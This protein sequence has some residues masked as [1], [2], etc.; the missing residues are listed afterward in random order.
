MRAEFD[1]EFDRE[2]D[3]VLER[4]KQSHDLTVVQDLLA[5]WRHHAY[6][7]MLEPG[8]YYRMSADAEEVQRTGVAPRGSVDGEEIK[9]LVQQRLGR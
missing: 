9:S 3:Q 4:A 1:R 8:S 7:E 2:W 5:K 6:M